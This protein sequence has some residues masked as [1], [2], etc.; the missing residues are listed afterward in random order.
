M[1]GKQRPL[2]SADETA[3]PP[4]LSSKSNTVVLL[5]DD[6]VLVSV[7]LVSVRVVLDVPEPDVCLLL[8]PDVSVPDV[9][10]VSD[11]PATAAVSHGFEVGFPSES[12]IFSGLS[13]WQAYLPLQ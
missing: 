10:R 1:H 7:I 4:R 6:S 3:T 9:T 5:S 13:V 2:L 8:L 11:P 12:Q